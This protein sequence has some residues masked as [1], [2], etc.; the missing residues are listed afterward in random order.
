[1]ALKREEPDLI[2]R[3]LLAAS[4][5]GPG[6]WLC[7]LTAVLILMGL[8]LAFGAGFTLGRD[9]VQRERCVISVEGRP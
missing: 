2:P 7:T 9:S 3:R 4:V 8:V 6:R 1:M 5:E